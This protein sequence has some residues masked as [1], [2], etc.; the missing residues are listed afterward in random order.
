MLNTSSLAKS[1]TLNPG[2]RRQVHVTQLNKELQITS[3]IAKGILLYGLDGA[4]PALTGSRVT[5]NATQELHLDQ[6]DYQYDYFYLNQ[7]SSLDVTIDQYSGASNMFLLRGPI[8]DDTADTSFGQS[9]ILKQYATKGHTGRLQYTVPYS[10]TYVVVFDN[11]SNSKGRASVKYHVDLTSYNL[12]GLLPFPCQTTNICTIDLEKTHGCILIQADKLVTIH[13]TS[14]RKW[15]KIAFWVALPLA[16]GFCC[17][18]PKR[19]NLEENPPATNPAVI[20]TAPQYEAVSSEEQEYVVPWTDILPVA[21][22][23][24]DDTIL[25]SGTGK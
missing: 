15:G 21:T 7:G 25:P 18:R 1:W 6:G 16:I 5:L 3:S 17:F 4:C 24:T 8:S 10:D 22:L 2:E 20:P 13:I 14:S 23:V 9:A 11:A 19:Q 12:V